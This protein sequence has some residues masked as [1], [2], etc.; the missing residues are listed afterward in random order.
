MTY[1]GNT[2]S[3][4]KKELAKLFSSRDWRT[5]LK[6]YAAYSLLE[7][8]AQN[9]KTVPQHKSL[10]WFYQFFQ[11]KAYDPKISH[12]WLYPPPHRFLFLRDFSKILIF[13]IFSARKG[14][15]KLKNMS[16]DPINKAIL[17]IFF[18]KWNLMNPIY[19]IKSRLLPQHSLFLRDNTATIHCTFFVVE[20]SI[21]H[22][23][24]CPPETNLLNFTIGFRKF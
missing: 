4:L 21:K 19:V 12:Q 23:R 16:P 8:R 6:F 18:Y 11:I 9:R 5:P 22:K 15:L 7:K 3:H 17:F 20:I 1:L 10:T 2:G 24:F 14:S 13:C